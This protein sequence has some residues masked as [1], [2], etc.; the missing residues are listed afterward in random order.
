MARR[1][2]FHDERGKD[3][4][5]LIA[6]L[7]LVL[8]ATGCGNTEQVPPTRAAAGQTASPV[9]TPTP[10]AMTVAQARA[11]YLKIVAPYNTA[12]EKFET[13]ANA[14]RSLTSLRTLARKVAETN[15]AHATAL[16]AAAWPPQV[17]TSMAAMLT[18]TDAAQRQWERAGRA[19]TVEE[20]ASAVRAAAGHSGAK[21]ASQVRS[22]LGLPP[23]S[24]S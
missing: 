22:A 24:E 19:K 18:E 9:P 21:P 20:L 11:R 3:M 4:R 16:R 8:V 17:H 2:L 5:R 15:A 6:A 12:L 23:Y 14:G 13:A 1:R 10:A 7:A